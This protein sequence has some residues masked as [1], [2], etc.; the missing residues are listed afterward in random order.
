MIEINPIDHGKL[1]ACQ[2]ETRASIAGMLNKEM[3]L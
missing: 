2:Q 3:V 1:K